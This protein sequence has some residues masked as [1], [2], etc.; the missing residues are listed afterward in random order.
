METMTK[1]IKY[2]LENLK[3]DHHQFDIIAKFIFR[4]SRLQRNFKI[5]QINIPEK[6]YKRL[7]F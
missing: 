1:N 3:K 2:T 6:T 5:D 4:L 7:P